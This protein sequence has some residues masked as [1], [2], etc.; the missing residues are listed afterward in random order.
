MRY[1]NHQYQDSNDDDDYIDI[2]SVSKMADLHRA[3]SDQAG[4]GDEQNGYSMPRSQQ[5][6]QQQRDE[7][8][9]EEDVA[10]PYRKASLQDES[11]D[12][13]NDDR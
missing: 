1:G 4:E 5:H 6:Q 3:T 13:G 11:N 12:Q 2:A 9:V 10:D 8:E 7:E